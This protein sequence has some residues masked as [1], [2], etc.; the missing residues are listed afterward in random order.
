M[1]DGTLQ[2]HPYEDHC[3]PSP[4]TPTGPWIPPTDLEILLRVFVDD[5][6]KGVA[7]PPARTTRYAEERWL[8]RAVLHAIHALFP[9]PDITGHTNGRDSISLKKLLAGDGL[10]DIHKILLG[11][12][13]DGSPHQS[14]TIALPH[15]KVD[16][17][18]AAILDALAA[19]R[20]FLS[21]TAYQKLYGK[22]LHASMAMPCISEF[23]SI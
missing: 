11:F 12:L 3:V 20:H 16:S 9:H 17:Y 19:P 4:V 5:Y 10:F 18:T 15:E 7:G 2:P 8:C 13:F 23:M 14:R 6:V 1:H 22:L 21:R